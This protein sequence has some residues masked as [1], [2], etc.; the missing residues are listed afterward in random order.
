MGV[1]PRAE[2]REPMLAVH[3]DDALVHNRSV[4]RT[5]LRD[6]IG[7]GLIPNDIAN[8][9]GAHEGQCAMSRGPFLR[10]ARHATSPRVTSRTP[11]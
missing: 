7:L 8:I 4:D 5:D 1:R 9:I 11:Q 2:V 6:G 10:A 3:D